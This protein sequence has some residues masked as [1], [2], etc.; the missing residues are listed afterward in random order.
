MNQPSFILTNDKDSNSHLSYDIDG[1]TGL[2][3]RYQYFTAKGTKNF[4]VTT[5]AED[6]DALPT[7]T[8]TDSLMFD[9]Y[10]TNISK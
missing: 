8:Y 7:G 1:G 10:I 6:W 3:N 2:L 4:V 9:V 5:D